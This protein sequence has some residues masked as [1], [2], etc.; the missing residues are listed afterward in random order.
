MR[1]LVAVIVAIA[2]VPEDFFKLF[3]RVFAGG[4]HLEKLPNHLRLLIVDGKP[5]LVL[6]VVE[7]PVVPEDDTLLYRLLMTE[8]HA[9]T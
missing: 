9:G 4:V 6:F 8:F 3:H 7:N 1:N 5:T 2:L